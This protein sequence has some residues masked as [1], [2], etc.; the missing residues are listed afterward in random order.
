M[1]AGMTMEAQ[2]TVR[3]AGLLVVQRGL[4]VAG[5]FIFAILV[6]FALF[7]IGYGGL[8]FLLRVVTM[9]EIVAMWQAIRHRR[10][11]LEPLAHIG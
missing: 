1:Q 7:L 6:L 4:L 2:A 8:L 3:N 10:P 9:G 11:G 5:G